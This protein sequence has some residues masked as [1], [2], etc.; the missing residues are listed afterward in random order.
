[1]AVNQ[2]PAGFVLDQAPAQAPAGL[3]AGFVMDQPATAPP[4]AAQA[5]AAAQQ[6]PGAS[7]NP[8][9]VPLGIAET[10][11]SIGAGAIGQVA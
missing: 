2:L 8:L 6:Q 7:F 3:P 10:A 5:P 4:A 11:G 9:E 1:M